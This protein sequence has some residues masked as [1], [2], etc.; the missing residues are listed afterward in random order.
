MGLYKE[1]KIHTLIL[2]LL[3]ITAFMAIFSPWRLGERE[4]YWDED[5]YAVQTLEL[6]NSP[7]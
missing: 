4:L 1:K 3:L 2:I 7:L 5:Y 6:E